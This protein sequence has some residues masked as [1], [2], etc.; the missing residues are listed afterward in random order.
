MSRGIYLIFTVLIASSCAVNHNN[1]GGNP[2]DPLDPQ[3]GSALFKLR[4]E[5]FSPTKERFCFL[6]PLG[7]EEEVEFNLD[8]N[9]CS[10]SRPI[11]ALGRAVRDVWNV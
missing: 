1:A 8:L 11:D 9:G 3:E 2:V 6:R 7:K 5:F 10:F 4:S